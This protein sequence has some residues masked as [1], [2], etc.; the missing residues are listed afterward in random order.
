MVKLLATTVYWYLYCRVYCWTCNKWKA[1]HPLFGVWFLLW[2]VPSFPYALCTVTSCCKG[3]FSCLPLSSCHW[4]SASCI[5]WGC[6]DLIATIPFGLERKWANFPLVPSQRVMDWKGFFLYPNRT[7][8]VSHIYATLGNIMINHF[9]GGLLDFC[10]Q[11][12]EIFMDM[13]MLLM[14]HTL[15]PLPQFQRL[16]VRCLVRS[17]TSIQLRTFSLLH[18]FLLPLKA[19]SSLLTIL[20]SQQLKQ[21]L[22]R[23]PLTVF[24]MV[25]LTVTVELYPLRQANKIHHWRLM[26]LIGHP[27]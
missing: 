12:M 19:T 23:Q 9:N 8:C 1:V 26:E 14:G 16:M 27:C 15:L 17:I 3:C 20:K 5:L 6:L 11:Y 7:W 10:R 2:L 25:L 18:Q 24:Q 22:P 4:N 13:G 21:I